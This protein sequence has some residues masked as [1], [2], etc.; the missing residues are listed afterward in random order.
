ME[1]RWTGRRMLR[2]SQSDLNILILANALD[3]ED[4]NFVGW[5]MTSCLRKNSLETI[6]TKRF[7]LR[8]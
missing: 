4:T 7:D 1:R 6:E 5:M 2:T 8:Q 3:Y